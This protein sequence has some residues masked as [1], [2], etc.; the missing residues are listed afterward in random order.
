MVRDL[1]V[2][3]HHGGRFIDDNGTYVGS[4]DEKEC[5]SDVWGYFEVVDLVNKLGYIEIEGLND[6]P[7]NE[8]QLESEDSALDVRFGDSDDEVGLNDTVGVDSEVDD[9]DDVEGGA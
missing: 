9:D 8:A 7:N 4:V 5:D 2:H 3:F 1:N 6:T